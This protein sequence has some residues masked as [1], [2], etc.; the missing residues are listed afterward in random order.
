MDPDANL[1]EQLTIVT[2]INAINDAAVNG[3]ATT[4]ELEE[5]DRLSGRLAELVESLD[6]WLRKG[7]SL[8]RR[9]QRR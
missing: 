6:E 5:L 8:P 3:Q 1:A 7:G 4:T 9:W 2:A